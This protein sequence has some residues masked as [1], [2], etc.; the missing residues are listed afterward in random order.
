MQ[1]RDQVH[2][3]WLRLEHT[4]ICCTLRQLPGIKARNG[5]NCQ[6]MIGKLQRLPEMVKELPGGASTDNKWCNTCRAPKANHKQHSKSGTTTCKAHSTDMH[7]VMCSWQMCAGRLMHSILIYGVLLAERGRLCMHGHS[8]KIKC[9]KD[10]KP[11]LHR[12]QRHS[13][14]PHLLYWL[15][16]RFCSPDLTLQTRSPAQ[17]AEL[18]V[19]RLQLHINTKPFN[20]LVYWSLSYICSKR[21]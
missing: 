3:S 7:T 12:R 17:Q 8:K 2:W 20:C 10:N 15:L 6:V 18:V 11:V 5:S 19:V 9:S 16:Q 13:Q 1:S 4:L 21:Q 14:T